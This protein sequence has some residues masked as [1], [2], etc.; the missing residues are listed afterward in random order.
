LL[1]KS[2][3]YLNCVERAEAMDEGQLKRNKQ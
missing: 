1:S 2:V 3:K